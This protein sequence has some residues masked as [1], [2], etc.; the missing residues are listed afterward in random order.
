LQVIGLLLDAVEK[1]RVESEARKAGGG[2]W[3][4]EIEEETCAY[5]TLSSGACTD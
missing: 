1:R 5:L 3:G 2:S 4:S